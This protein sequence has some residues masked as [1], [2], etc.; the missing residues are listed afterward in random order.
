MLIEVNDIVI[1]CE[2]HGYGEPVLMVMGSGAGGK[3]WR[4]HQVPALVAGGYKVI[5][6]DNRGIG[7]SSGG[8]REF[9]LEEMISDVI[10]LVEVLR[11]GP[12][13]MVGTSLGSQVIQEVA[14]ARPDLVSRM[15]LVATRGRE[16]Y[17]REYYGR[18][19]LALHE[20]RGQIP[21]EY[22]AMTEALC[23]L[24]PHTLSD[25]TAARD[26][27]ETFSR[28][29]K[30]DPGYL[31]QLRI[32]AHGDRLAEYRKITTPTHVIAFEDDVLTPPHLG[33][34]VAAAIPDATFEVISGCGHLGY[35]ERPDG[36]NR[37]ILGFL[38]GKPVA[39]RPA[40]P[41]PSR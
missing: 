1:D 10:G 9:T 2:Q 6:F 4:A 14:L 23:N 30:D 15:V 11:L 40:G 34:E 32:K 35:L 28:V 38:G 18:A 20:S 7:G 19:V 27:L 33:Q 17:A 25:D 39:D 24:S 16:D 21:V 22:V 3:V 37:S 29:D 12:C 41:G 13:R 31:S 26:W 36:V 8:D 5:T